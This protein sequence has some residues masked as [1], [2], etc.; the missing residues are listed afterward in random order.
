MGNSDPN[1]EKIKSRLVK[2][3]GHLNAV[4]RMVDENK[5]C[6]D[7]LHQLKAVQAALDRVS[8][9]LLRQHL[10]RCVAEALRNGDEKRM[11]E[12]LIQIFRKSPS[13]Y[14]AEAATGAPAA[15]GPSLHNTLPH[16]SLE[17]ACR[18]LCC[19]EHFPAH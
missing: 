8:E 5:Y 9:E 16:H 15:V 4:H 11:V 13:L 10:Q 14:T 2:A 6:I 7:V 1:T 3:M 17:Y 18:D 19:Q 12:E